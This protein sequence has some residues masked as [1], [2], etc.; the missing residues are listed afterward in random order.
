MT[1]MKPFRIF[2][3]VGIGA[4][5]TMA[6]L[7]THDRPEEFTTGCIILADQA[8]W[9]LQGKEPCEGGTVALLLVRDNTS[10]KQ[11]NAMKKR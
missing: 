2:G 8:R 5:Q 7:V 3:K 6:R 9:I 11:R 10:R 4:A 1:A